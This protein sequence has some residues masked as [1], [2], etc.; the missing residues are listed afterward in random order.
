MFLL[1]MSAWHTR[2][3]PVVESVATLVNA[4]VAS[5][6]DCCNALLANSPKVTTDK[7]QRVLN[8][9]ARVVTGMKK[10]D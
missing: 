6:I 1:V 8:A 2:R 4:F 9:A 3:S 10:F 5:H 7:L